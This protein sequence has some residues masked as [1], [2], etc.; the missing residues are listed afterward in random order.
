MIFPPKALAPPI[1]VGGSSAINQA[2]TVN[3]TSSLIS[4]IQLLTKSYGGL[5]IQRQ[6]K[7]VIESVAT[8]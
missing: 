2:F 5:L 8:C 3:G 6:Q 7:V 1:S 4:H